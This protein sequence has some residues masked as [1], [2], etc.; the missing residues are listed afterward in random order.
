MQGFPRFPWLHGLGETNALIG[1]SSACC[2][3]GGGLG[4]W[5]QT[6]KGSRT[7]APAAAAEE[8]AGVA[9]SLP[10][11]SGN[12]RCD[13]DDGKI[14]LQIYRYAAAAL[15]HVFLRAPRQVWLGRE[16]LGDGVRRDDD[17]DGRRS[18][19]PP[20]QQKRTAQ[21]EVGVLGWARVLGWWVGGICPRAA[22]G[23]RSEQPTTHAP[24][25]IGAHR[26]ETPWV[27]VAPPFVPPGVGRGSGQRRRR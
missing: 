16:G 6:S 1:H 17:D 13:G 4:W 9:C 19:Q 3:G 18:T 7:A 20:Q 5:V 15:Q 22:G 14:R 21:Q 8:E 27:D 24:R 26:P 10:M 11:G 23:V 25:G 12:T 2:V